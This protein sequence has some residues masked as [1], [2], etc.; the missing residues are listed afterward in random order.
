MMN[1]A[2]GVTRT[3]EKCNFVRLFSR[4][5]VVFGKGRVTGLFAESIRSDREQS[6]F[7]GHTNRQ[8]L[9]SQSSVC[10]YFRCL[11]ALSSTAA[12]TG[13]R[14]GPFVNLSI[15][16][17]IRVFESTRNCSD[18]VVVSASVWD[19]RKW[20]FSVESFRP[21]TVLEGRLLRPSP[22]FIRSAPRRERGWS[23]SETSEKCAFS[24]VLKVSSNC[25]SDIDV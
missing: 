5:V 21:S 17:T 7:S 15:H 24:C 13:R 11:R 19:Y 18:I 25:Y 3:Y 14:L 20:K 4:Y 9:A 8:P 16:I 10:I 22:C 2:S 1:F 6:D 23:L 12:L